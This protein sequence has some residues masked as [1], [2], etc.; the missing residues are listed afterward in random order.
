MA[1]K[2]KRAGAPKKDDKERLDTFALVSLTSAQI[3]ISKMLMFLDGTDKRAT[4][5]REYYL[6]AVYQTLR[7]LLGPYTFANKGNFNFLT[8]KPLDFSQHNS[9]KELV[10]EFKQ[11]I[12]KEENGTS[13]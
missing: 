9:I 11:T 6:K 1:P 8:R 5:V 12:K 4:H 7:E 10:N 2:R 3:E 13:K